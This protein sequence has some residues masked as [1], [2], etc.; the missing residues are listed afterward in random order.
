MS[1]FNLGGDIMEQPGS[2]ATGFM[3]FCLC[4]LSIHRWTGITGVWCHTQQQFYMGAGDLTSC[5][6]VYTA[7]PEPSPQD[8]ALFF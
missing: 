1:C 6:Q 2:L 4:L 3:D 7:S 5:P 8:S